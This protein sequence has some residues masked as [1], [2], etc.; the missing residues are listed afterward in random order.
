[1]FSTRGY[2][3]ESLNVAPTDD[4]AVFTGHA[5][6]NTPIQQISLQLLKL[7]DVVDV[8]DVTRGALRAEPLVKIKGKA[9]R[10]RSPRRSANGVCSGMRRTASIELTSS[11][12]TSTASWQR[13]VQLWRLLE[14]VQRRARDLAREVLESYLHSYRR[15][16]TVTGPSLRHRGCTN[17]S[18]GIRPAPHAG[19]S[20]NRTGASP[21]SGPG[22]GFPESRDV[23]RR[24]IA[25]LLPTHSSAA[26]GGCA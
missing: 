2:N 10:W 12:V 18:T 1:M 26:C 5:G 16:A 7:V 23:I 8:E 25:P 14:V 20:K 19:F 6:G 3:I 15:P 21:R 9:T 4:P 11:E 17:S 13:G 24:R 22:Q